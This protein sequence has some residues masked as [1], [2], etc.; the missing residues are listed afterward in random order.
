MREILFR[1][2]DKL[3]V[4]HYGSLHI[5]TLGKENKYYINSNISIEN[6]NFIEVN[7]ESVG[8]FTGEKDCINDN[9][10]FEGMTVNQKETVTG[11]DTD[12]TGEVKI[13]NGK[14]WIDDNVLAVPLWSET[15]ENKILSDI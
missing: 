3:G 10:I 1:G 5:D 2:K 7:A 4:W 13:Y 11:D 6:P 12:F 8:E 15:A 9:M 14:W